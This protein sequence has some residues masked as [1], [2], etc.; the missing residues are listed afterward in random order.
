[1]QDIVS[2]FGDVATYI[3]ENASEQYCSQDPD[4][5]HYDTVV[6]NVGDGKRLALQQNY[7]A[8]G[9]FVGQVIASLSPNDTGVSIASTSPAQPGAVNLRFY[10]E[11]PL[12]N[13][14][15]RAFQLRHWAKEIAPFIGLS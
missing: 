10:P 3:A 6:A 2:A 9:A 11:N 5:T 12:W 15:T 8:Q 14:Y 4:G 13:E 7:N 1:M